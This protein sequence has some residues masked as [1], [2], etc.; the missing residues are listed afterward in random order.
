MRGNVLLNLVTSISTTS[1]HP[2][3]R[4]QSRKPNAGCNI[5]LVTRISTTSAHPLLRDQ[6]RKPNAGCNILTEFETVLDYKSLHNITAGD[7]GQ[8]SYL[9]IIFLFVVVLFIIRE[10]FCISAQYLLQPS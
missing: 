9:K 1:A 6:S 3:L 8:E 7:C 10:I 4:D 2:L 5:N